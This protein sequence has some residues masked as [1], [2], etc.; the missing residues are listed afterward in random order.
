MISE[1]AVR[2]ARPRECGAVSG[3][4][5]RSC[6]E[7]RNTH[8]RDCLQGVWAFKRL[9]PL[10]HQVPWLQVCPRHHVLKPRLSH[11]RR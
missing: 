7:E 1:Q 8:Q 5:R 4:V 6:G 11:L 2:E 9:A 3:W 10:D